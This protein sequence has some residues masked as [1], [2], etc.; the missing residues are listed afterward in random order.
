PNSGRLLEIST[1]E[2][3]VQ[4]YSGNFLNGTRRG[5]GGWMYRQGD[6]MCFETQHFPDS[7]NRPE[8]PSVRLEPG[9]V[10]RSRTVWRF[11]VA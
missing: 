2:P 11:G 5:K 10:W 1:T 8:F 9:Q 4:F 6:G 3:G 7:P